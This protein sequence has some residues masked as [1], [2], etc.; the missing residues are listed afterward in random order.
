M[1]NRI[2]GL[3]T[4]DNKPTYVCFQEDPR[5]TPLMNCVSLGDLMY[6]LMKCRELDEKEGI[7]KK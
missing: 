6:T 2:S 1:R 7:V 3:G 5:K 4:E